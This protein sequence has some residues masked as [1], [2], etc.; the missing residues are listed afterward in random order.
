MSLYG[1]FKNFKCLSPNYRENL[2]VN[3][4]AVS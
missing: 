2:T 4:E 3:F 1:W